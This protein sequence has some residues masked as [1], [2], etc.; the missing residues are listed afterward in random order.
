MANLDDPVP[1]NRPRDT[2]AFFNAAG[3][4]LS[5]LVTL[6]TAWISWGFAAALFTIGVIWTL[7]AIPSIALA[8]EDA[9]PSRLLRRLLPC[10]NF[11]TRYFFLLGLATITFSLLLW[12]LG[13]AEARLRDHS[14]PHETSSLRIEEVIFGKD[15]HL[16]GRGRSSS[17]R[18]RELSRY[19]EWVR[20][21][22]QAVDAD[23]RR[24]DT[25][26]AG[27]PQTTG[28]QPSDSKKL[29]FAVESDPFEKDYAAFHAELRITPTVTIDDC[30]VLLVRNDAGRWGYRPRLRQVDVVPP[31]GKQSCHCF[32][33]RPRSG[34]RLVFLLIL[35]CPDI[36]TDPQQV[37]ADRQIHVH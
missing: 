22:A 5:S 12:W 16:I 25:P 24:V 20:R 32:V 23:A 18:A 6:Y 9:W 3:V 28:V 8:R 36:P 35:D 21:F 26:P 33:P 11:L 34:E 19:F 37:L 2:L 17:E 7:V 27:T 1:A 31:S 14:L 10:V 13:I 29:F 30:F 15:F 4:T